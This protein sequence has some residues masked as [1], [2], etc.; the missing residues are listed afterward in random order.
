MSIRVLVT[1]YQKA[2]YNVNPFERRDI[3]SSRR[4]ENPYFVPKKW[5]FIDS[6]L[7]KSSSNC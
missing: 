4:K 7:E 3:S 2:S 6:E 5:R 1:V